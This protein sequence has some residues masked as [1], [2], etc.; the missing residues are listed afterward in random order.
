MPVKRRKS[1]VR[2][3]ELRAW[4]TWFECGYDF[5][6]DLVDAG[7][8]DHRQVQ[9]DLEIARDAWRRCGE[10]W[11]SQYRARQ[12]QER[13]PREDDPHAL[14]MFGMPRGRGR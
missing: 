5:F 9:P 2:P 3:D 7:I 8:V 6:G 13:Y 10:V 14:A 1:K 12:A 4:N 11:L